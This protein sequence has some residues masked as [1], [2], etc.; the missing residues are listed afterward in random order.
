MHDSYFLTDIFLY[1]QT[2]LV[3]WK[4]FIEILITSHADYEQNIEKISNF[5]INS[6]LHCL[7]LSSL[8]FK[9]FNNDPKTTRFYLLQMRIAHVYFHA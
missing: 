9:N 5:L 2:L 3:K 8:S 4:K 6:I 7:Q 1:F